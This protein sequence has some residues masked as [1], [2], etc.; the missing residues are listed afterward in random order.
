[1]AELELSIAY[2]TLPA[3]VGVTVMGALL[4]VWGLVV[5]FC[6]GLFLSLVMRMPQSLPPVLTAL[7]LLILMLIPVLSVVV[8]AICEDDQILISK[9]GLSFPLILLPKLA[10]RRERL[11]TDLM[12]ASVRWSSTRSFQGSDCLSLY[13]RSGGRAN[14]ALKGIAKT[15]LEQLLLAVEVWG[16]NCKREPLLIEFQNTL[17]NENK[18]LE[19]LSYT[20]MWEEE[21]RRRFN[22]TSFVPLEPGRLLQSGRLRIVRQLAFGG[23]SAIYLAQSNEQRLVVVKEAVVPSNADQESRCKASEL[24]AREAQLLIRLQHAQIAQVLD[25]F[26]E[27]GRNYLVLEYIDGQDLRQLVKQHGAQPE[28]LVLQWTGEMAGILAY[29]HGQHPPIIHRDLTPDNLVL[30]E[31]GSLVLIDFGAANEFVGTATGTLVGKQAYIAPEQF[32]GKAV[33]QSDLYALGCTLYFLLTGA[34][35][36]ALSV[37]EPRERASQVSEEING[38]V[39]QCTSLEAKGR[40]ESAEQVKAAVQAIVSTRV[41]SL[42]PSLSGG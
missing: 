37:S 26:V 28:A 25:H 29:L 27:D 3:R 22:S 24:F 9:E 42:E 36:E 11:W 10:F 7:V 2:K 5:P 41:A 30:R 33:T 4:P 14:L 15:D 23:L 38:L 6:L 12:A 20:Q 39:A 1:V 34:D 17:Q 21:L 16:G 19:H 32:R 40:P 8:T 13:F 35:P 31:D 18:G